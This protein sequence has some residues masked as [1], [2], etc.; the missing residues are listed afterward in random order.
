MAATGEQ[1]GTDPISRPTF[2]SK[3]RR[4]S[5]PLAKQEDSIE[6]PLKAWSFGVKYFEVGELNVFFVWS[7]KTGTVSV[8]RRDSVGPS[9]SMVE[10]T[11]SN[12]KDMKVRFFLLPF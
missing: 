7:S 10:I 2:D 1:F 5:P 12:I 9:T 11:A 3:T 8:R 6:L 4:K